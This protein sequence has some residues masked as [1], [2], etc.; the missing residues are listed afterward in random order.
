MRT[1]ALRLSAISCAVFSCM[2]STAVFA[3]INPGALPVEAGAQMYITP[4]G[5]RMTVEQFQANTVLK[6]IGITGAW[7]RGYTGKGSTIA[8]LDQ[9]F[10]LKHSDLAPNVLAY[11]NFYPGSI[12]AANANWGLHGTAMASVAAGDLNGGKGTVGAAFDAN[13][14]LGQVGQGGSMPNINTAAVVQGLNWAG[15][16]G[17]VAVNM[18]F[19]SSFDNTYIAGTKQ[20]AT[21]VYQGNT[22]YGAMYGQVS[23]FNQFKA[24]TNTTSVVVAAAGNQGLA[25]S[26]F[27]GAFATATNADGSLVFGG[28]WLIVGSVDAN[29]KLS[30]FSNA[31]G[32]ICTNV[33]NGSCKDTYQV[34]DF[35][36][37]APGERVAVAMDRSAAASSNAT[38]M[39]GTSPATALVSGGIAV[40]KQA[41]P[42]L[43]AAEIVQLIKS[44]ATDLGKPGVDEVYGYGLVNFDKATQPLADVKYSKV[45]LKSGTSA[46]GTALNTTGITTSGPVATALSNSNVLK[47]VQ[48]VD[49]IN[50][51]FTADFTRAVGYNSNQFTN[52]FAL[53][54]WLAMK[55]NYREATVPVNKQTS[56]SMMQNDTGFASQF[57]TVYGDSRVSFQVGAMSEKAGFLNNSGSGLF[58][59]GDSTT[60]FA[61]IGGSKPITESIDVIGS[62]G[63]GVTRV[64]NVSDSMIQVSPTVISDTWKLGVAKKEVFFNGKTKDQFTFAVQGPASIRKGYAQVTAI[65]GYTYSGAEDD[66]TASPVTNSE[67]VN[68]ANG[69][70]QMDLVAGYSISTGPFN[71]AG[72]SIAKQFNVNGQPGKDGYAVNVM[73]RWAF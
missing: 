34:K 64:A 8:I 40:I 44:T 37:V 23:T 50:R 17:A 73:T 22:K 55:P 35:Y 31:A 9:G 6:Q 19:S 4:T 36:V 69:T 68:L 26:G 24:S 39:N 1:P 59:L 27:P 28:R 41:W 46:G 43:K 66:V 57:E 47:N 7:S 65:T 38:F 3:Q 71:F 52:S 33:V 49:G 58:A 15:Q 72:V 14:L 60:T 61:M 5:Q 30:T 2:A 67:R 63:V 62:Y 10:N 13:L 56:L 18:S 29:N 45:Q 53:S 12:S 32:H 54:P 25:Y 20:I 51:N 21:G 16:Q 70:R 42:Q 11:K 48:V